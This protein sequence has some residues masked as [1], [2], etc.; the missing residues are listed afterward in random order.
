MSIVL[1]LIVLYLFLS[2]L[3][4]RLL[5]SKAEEGS[6]D[7]SCRC[8]CNQMVWYRVLCDKN[9]HVTHVGSEFIASRVFFLLIY[10]PHRDA[11]RSQ[12]C[13]V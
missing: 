2:E 11:C 8:Y 10:A 1:L 5:V 4:V 9:R 12:I 3:K 13:D 6:R 7:F